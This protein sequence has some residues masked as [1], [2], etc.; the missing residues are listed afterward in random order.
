MVFIVQRG[1]VSYF[2]YP[3]LIL[4]L[5]ILI[6]NNNLDLTNNYFFISFLILVIYF[7]ITFLINLKYRDAEV[8]FRI[9]HDFSFYR[10]KQLKSDKEF[11]DKIKKNINNNF[12][13]WGSR[14]LC[15]LVTKYDQTF[16][17]YVSHNHIVYWSQISDK[18]NYCEKIA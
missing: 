14:T 4:N 17:E 3:L 13:L 5:F 9:L 7:L 12:Y 16:D 18:R 15:C 1:Y 11:F 2:Y 6:K 8:T 10:V